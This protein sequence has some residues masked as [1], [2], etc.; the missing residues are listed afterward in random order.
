MGQR[1][2]RGW[3]KTGGWVMFAQAMARAPEALVGED[4]TTGEVAAFQSD[5]GYE[6][7]LDIRVVGRVF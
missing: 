3:F 2:S 1:A 5:P 7:E 6:D 4:Q